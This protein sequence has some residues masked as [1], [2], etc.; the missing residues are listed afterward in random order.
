M[1]KTS[2]YHGD[3]PVFCRIVEASRKWWKNRTEASL[4]E[5]DSLGFCRIL[6]DSCQREKTEASLY[7]GRRLK[8]VRKSLC[9]KDSWESSDRSTPGNLQD[10]PGLFPM[11]KNTENSLYHGDS[12]E[13]SK[14]LEA[15]CQRWKEK[16]KNRPTTRILWESPGFPGIAAHGGK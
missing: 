14:I 1:L 6:R 2:L 7:K 11:E 4:Y 13:F 10:S 15:S 8:N 5:E 3:S 16:L 9:H 12:P